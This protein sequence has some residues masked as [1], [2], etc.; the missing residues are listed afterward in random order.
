[1][2]KRQ[3]SLTELHELLSEIWPKI[4]NA[5]CT[6]PEG[7]NARAFVERAVGIA[8]FLTTKLID[9]EAAR[10]EAGPHTEAPRR[11]GPKA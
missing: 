1:M 5:Q 7:D 2:S 8:S 10:R 4:Y 3:L 9:E 6:S 11:Q